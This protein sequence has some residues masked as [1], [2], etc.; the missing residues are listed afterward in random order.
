MAPKVKLG[1]A[2]VAVLLAG[3]IVAYSMGWTTPP[4][5]KNV[6]ATI[7]CGKCNHT[8]PTRMSD[9]FKNGWLDTG[10]GWMVKCSKCGEPAEIRREGVTTGPRQRDQ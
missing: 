8:E 3:G 5:G 9:V 4:A 10:K 2:L 1:L 7:V 6:D